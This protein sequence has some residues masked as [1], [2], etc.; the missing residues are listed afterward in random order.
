MILLITEWRPC[1]GGAR[2]YASS[3]R[4]AIAAAEREPV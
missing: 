4:A 1:Q 2:W 3:V